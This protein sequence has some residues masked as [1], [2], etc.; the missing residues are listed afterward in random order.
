MPKGL[1]EGG[2]RPSES[3]PGRAL[4]PAA[5]PQDQGGCATSAPLRKRVISWDCWPHT[6]N[7]PAGAI[8]PPGTFQSVYPS[9]SYSSTLQPCFSAK[10]RIPSLQSGT[11]AKKGASRR[12]RVPRGISLPVQRDCRGFHAAAGLLEEDYPRLRLDVGAAAG[13]GLR[14]ALAKGYEVEP[15]TNG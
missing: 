7:C 14:G 13:R 4:Y 10:L 15:S 5:S 12:Y 11:S 3:K 6:R 9:A 2:A 8:K 1:L